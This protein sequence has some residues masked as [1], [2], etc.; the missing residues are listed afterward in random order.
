M[1]NDFMVISQDSDYPVTR[2]SVAVKAGAR[3]E[4]KEAPGLSHAL[5]NAVSL[6]RHLICK[7]APL[8]LDFNIVHEILHWIRIVAEFGTA[9]RHFKVTSI[10]TRKRTFLN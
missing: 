7:F 9:R 8:S 10:H 5:R 3:H 2:I 4:P 6:V 1:P